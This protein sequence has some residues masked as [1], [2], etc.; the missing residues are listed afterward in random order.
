MKAWPQNGGSSVAAA[1]SI[2]FWIAKGELESG[3]NKSGFIN[4]SILDAALAIVGNAAGS[5]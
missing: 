5:R 4:Q 2:D 3:F 1:G